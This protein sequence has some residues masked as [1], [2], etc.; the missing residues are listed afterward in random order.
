MIHTAARCGVITRLAHGV[1]VATDA[2]PGDPTDAHLQRG[3]AH[4][5]L[6]PNAIAS[7]H[8]AALA[9]GLALDRPA[10]AAESPPAFIEAP[11]PGARSIADGTITVHVRDLPRHHRAEHP[12]GLIVTSRARSAV[13]VAAD[14]DLPAALI[15]LDS[16]ARFELL[17]QVG[18]RAI[19]THYVNARSLAAARAPLLEAAGVAATQFTR[20]ALDRTVPL[21]DPRRE[22]PLESLGYGEMVRAGFPLPELQ[23]AIET[24]LGTVYA[25]CL[26]RAQMVVGEADGLQKYDMDSALSNE[27]LR[28]EALE[29]LGYRVVRWGMKELRTSPMGVLWRVGAA[30]DARSGLHV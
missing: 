17:D 20:K 1:Y 21:A 9:W 2:I 16:A 15:T 5:I 11:R 4:Q 27:K 26:W 19:R 10:E 18:E 8:T 30:L 25:D 24:P 14:L 23:V 6:R 22:S 3:V 12:V 13:D 29:Q 28:Q 7:H